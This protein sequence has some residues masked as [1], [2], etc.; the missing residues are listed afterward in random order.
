ML[1]FS[2]ANIGRGNL[3]VMVPDSCPASHEF[4]PSATD[5]RG[6]EGLMFVKF[7]GTQSPVTGVMWKFSEGS[8][9]A[10][11]GV[12]TQSSTEEFSLSQA[13]FQKKKE[14]GG[15]Y[16]QPFLNGVEKGFFPFATG[17]VLLRFPCRHFLAGVH[18]YVLKYRS[19]GLCAGVTR[20]STAAAVDSF[21]LGEVQTG[22]GS[23]RL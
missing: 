18:G 15:T 11:I 14:K 12:T 19:V 3:V 2:P 1:L 13:L 16:T 4:K 9:P 22:T 5:A 8:V 23:Q 7:L 20:N 10:Q 21:S 17:E 6:V